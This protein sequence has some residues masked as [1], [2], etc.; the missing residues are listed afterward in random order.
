MDH[1]KG[2]GKKIEE[3]DGDI[4]NPGVIFDLLEVMSKV[5]PEMKEPF[6]QLGKRDIR[7]D[8]FGQVVLIKLY[9]RMGCQIKSGI[10]EKIQEA[11]YFSVVLNCTRDARSEEP[12]SLVIR[13]VDVSATPPKVEEFFLGFLELDG[14]SGEEIFGELKGVLSKLELDI[15]DVRGQGYANG[16]R[17][18]GKENDVQKRLPEINPRTFYTPCG[19]HTLNTALYNMVV[20]CPRASSYIG[21]FEIMY[22]VFTSLPKIWQYFTENVQDLTPEPSSSNRCGAHVGCVE[23]LR[24]KAPEILDALDNFIETEKY[25]L[26]SVSLADRLA[27]SPIFGIGNLEFLF[28]MIVWHNLLL[29]F[30]PVS[31]MLQTEDLQLDSAIGQLNGLISFIEKYR[32]TGFKE[33]MEEAKKVVIAMGF[34]SVWESPDGCFMDLALSLAKSRLELYQVYEEAFGF[35]FDL[36]KLHSAD[37]D[38]LRDSCAKLEEFLK[39]DNVSDID[40]SGLFSEL[41]FLK[42]VLPKETKKA[43]EVLSFLQ[44][45]NGYPNAWIAFRILLTIPISAASAERGS[46]LELIHSYLQLAMSEEASEGLAM[47]SIEL[48]MLEKLDTASVIADIEAKTSARQ[49]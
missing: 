41:K 30:D 15:G 29:A 10:V 38:S 44:G 32:Q 4:G 40:G 13:C 48:A 3:G 9:D 19:S 17:L 26:A 1:G 37:D 18:R 7:R 11:K 6:Q 20:C 21:C 42:E 16:H 12:T 31:K 49:T 24:F 8:N 35:L 28:G 25:D 45:T 33:A 14:K 34:E 27:N 36:K 43:I 23:A 39:H 47:V 22:S 5:D 46:K 2:K